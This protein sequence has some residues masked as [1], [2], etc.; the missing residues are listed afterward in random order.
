MKRIIAALG[1]AFVLTLAANAQ[2]SAVVKSA[3]LTDYGIYRIK[4]TG[5]HI[6]TATAESGAI[7]PA[8]E[9]ILIA[10]T[11]QVP[12]VVGTT[13]GFH[14]TLKEE[15]AGAPAQVVVIVKHPPFK[16]PNGEITGTTDRIPWWYRTDQRVGYTYTFDH[17]WE[18][19]PGVWT[20]EVWDGEQKLVA[21]EFAV[22]SDQ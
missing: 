19:A 18:A 10:K 5:E 11:N 6:M 4:L 21:Q 1:T 8:S 2:N 16:K 12:A 7:Q 14:F 9:S 3:T 22:Y 13:F 15:P 20:F 17:Q